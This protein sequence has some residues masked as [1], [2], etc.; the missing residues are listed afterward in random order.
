MNGKG[1]IE[2][3]LGDLDLKSPTGIKVEYWRNLE[4]Q[5]IDGGWYTAT[6]KGNAA[7]ESSCQLA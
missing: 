1:T 4:E 6:E 3:R 7:H 2:A 5:L